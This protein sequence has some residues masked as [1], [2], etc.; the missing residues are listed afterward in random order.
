MYAGRMRRFSGRAGRAVGLESGKTRIAA[1]VR[2][3]RAPD[4]DAVIAIVEES[5]QAAN[6]SRESYAKFAEESGSIVLVIESDGEVSGF[7]VGRLAGDQAEVLNLAVRARQR[8]RGAGTALLAAALEEFGLRGA[9]SVYLE[10]R[11]SNTGAIA[12]YERHGFAKTGRRKEY[13]RDPDEAA[14]TMKKKLGD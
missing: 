2:S 10:V 7:L 8:R 4:T 3:F 5:P 13:Y 6:W 11:E 14:V 9:N 1:A 12:F